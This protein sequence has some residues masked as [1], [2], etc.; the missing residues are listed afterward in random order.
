[1]WFCCGG[2]ADT[3]RKA[4]DVAAKLEK[5]AET[6]TALHEKRE[7]FRCIARR[8]S[9]LYFA[10]AEMADVNPMY[11]VCALAFGGAV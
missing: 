5:A 4:L 3:K 11:Q 6:R 9:A 8:G 10:V 2:T 1:M 7:V